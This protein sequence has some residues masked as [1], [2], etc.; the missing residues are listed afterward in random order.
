M[1]LYFVRWPSEAVDNVE[2]RVADGLGGASYN[3][4]NRLLK[5]S[6]VPLGRRHTHRT[7]INLLTRSGYVLETA[8]RQRVRQLSCRPG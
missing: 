1:I 5:Q 6:L 7:E 4:P 3:T 2:I 8:K